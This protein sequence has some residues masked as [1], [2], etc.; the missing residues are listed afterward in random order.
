MDSTKTAQSLNAGDYMKRKGAWVRVIG[1]KPLIT[2][3]EVVL[4]N[5]DKLELG[6]EAVVRYMTGDKHAEMERDELIREGKATEL[7][8]RSSQFSTQ[9][10]KMGAA[11]SKT[12]LFAGWA[13]G[14]VVGFI[15]SGSAIAFARS[16]DFAPWLQLVIGTVTWVGSGWFVRDCYEDLRL[17]AVA[18]QYN[19]VLR[20]LVNDYAIEVRDLKVEVKLL[21]RTSFETEV[22]DFI[23]SYNEAG[24]EIALGGAEPF[25]RM[26]EAILKFPVTKLHEQ[27][28]A[29]MRRGWE[30]GKLNSG[31]M[32][33]DLHR[34]QFDTSAERLCWQWIQA[35]TEGKR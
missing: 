28:V 2:T 19:E 7:A 20:K 17:G 32:I 13:V 22:G 31:G 18:R 14:I 3:V 29:A 9:I 11:P 34:D 27:L 15:V 23:H 5:G 1:V 6:L 16:L 30:E 24:V 10:E 4:D 26:A 25:G 8:R 33:T 21:K 35:M 12:H